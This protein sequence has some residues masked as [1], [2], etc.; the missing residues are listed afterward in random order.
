ME[1]IDLMRCET[2]DFFRGDPDSE[3]WRG[4]AVTWWKAVTRADFDALA[5]EAADARTLRTERDSLRQ[6]RDEARDALVGLKSLHAED[7]RV[8][9]KFAGEFVKAF[10]AGF[11]QMYRDSGAKNYLDIK[12]VDRTTGETYTVTV[13]RD[14]GKTAHALRT[15]AEAERD[16]ATARADKAEKDRDDARALAKSAVSCAS[17]YASD[18]QVGCLCVEECYCRAGLLDQLK[19]DLA[20]IDAEL[21]K[22]K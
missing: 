8:D 6:E 22:K 7:G 11:V 4:E 5:A 20:R 14:L 21:E 18:D 10:S 2:G 17:S 1:P 13:Q 15:E 12:F 19:A 16:A 9:A 3:K